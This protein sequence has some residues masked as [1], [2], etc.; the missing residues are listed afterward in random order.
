[1]CQVEFRLGLVRSGEFLAEE[2]FSFQF[3][4]KKLEESQPLLG[5]LKEMHP[6][7]RL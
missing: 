3:I 7:W 1:M 4:L 5:Q 2:R 6:L